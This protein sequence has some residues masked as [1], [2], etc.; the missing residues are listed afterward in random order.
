MTISLLLAAVT[1]TLADVA[2][3]LLLIVPGH[4]LER[5]PLIAPMAPTTALAARAAVV[6]AMVAFTIV[7]E[8]LQ[9][10]LVTAVVRI[11]LAAAIVVG[12]IGTASTLAAIA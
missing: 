11:G 1:A 5:N 8:E 10:R 3:F 9:A 4:A 2:A 6:V 7:S 12:V